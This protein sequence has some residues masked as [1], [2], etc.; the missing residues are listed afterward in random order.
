MKQL[1]K[2]CLRIVKTIKGSN[3]KRLVVTVK[4]PSS[5]TVFLVNSY[6]YD[7]L[8]CTGTKKFT[9]PRL[10]STFRFFEFFSLLIVTAD[11]AEAKNNRV[12]SARKLYQIAHKDFDIN[13]LSLQ[14]KTLYQAFLHNWETQ[15]FTPDFQQGLFS[16]AY[17]NK[18]N[19]YGV[20]SSK[21]YMNYIK[22]FIEEGIQDPKLIEII[23]NLVEPVFT[24]FETSNALWIAGKP[25]P[26]VICML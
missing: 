11:V 18:I 26:G 13:K 5:F 24:R 12:Q 14:S 20:R 9:A 23:Y 7:A 17:P 3:T 21:T 10:H 1:V 22:A 6:H 4:E 16:E 19:L 15:S 2:C 25:L 8:D